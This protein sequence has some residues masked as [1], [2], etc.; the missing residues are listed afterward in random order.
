MIDDKL[1]KLE[2]SLIASTLYVC[3]SNTYHFIWIEKLSRSNMKVRLYEILW[4]KTHQH[5]A[6]YNTINQLNNQICQIYCITHNACKTSVIE[7]ICLQS[8]LILAEWHQSTIPTTMFLNSRHLA[9][10]TPK[11]IEPVCQD[12]NTQ[13]SQIWNAHCLLLQY[14]VTCFFRLTKNMVFLSSLLA[15]Q[16]QGAC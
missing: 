15:F 16:K 2:N 8:Q 4:L 14:A 5:Q 13:I 7:K 12:F 9:M 11:Q 1:L 3:I 6:L 10:N